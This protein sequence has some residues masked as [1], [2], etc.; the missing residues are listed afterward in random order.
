VRRAVSGIK[1]Y[2]CVPWARGNL[3][4]LIGR[5]YSKSIKCVISSWVTSSC[6][7]TRSEPLCIWVYYIRHRPPRGGSQA[8]ML[9][10]VFLTCSSLSLADACLVDKRKRRQPSA[11]SLVVEWRRS[12]AGLQLQCKLATGYGR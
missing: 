8:G 4:T 7:A 3:L 11:S 1:S 5:L 2:V 10:V 6:M 12:A 9:L